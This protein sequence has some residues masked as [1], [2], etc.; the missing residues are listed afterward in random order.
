MIKPEEVMDIRSL[1]KQGYSMRA[2]ARLTG[3]HRETIKSYLKEGKLPTYRKQKR[4]I[5]VLNPY[6]SLIEGWLSQQN[7]QDSKIMSKVL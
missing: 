2:I 6:R 5:S 1:A 3:L 7:Y 4:K